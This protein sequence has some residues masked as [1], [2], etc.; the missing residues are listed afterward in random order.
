MILVA[1]GITA[2][3]RSSGPVV[4]SVDAAKPPNIVRSE[5]RPDQSKVA[6]GNSAAGTAEADR[7]RVEMDD[8]RAKLL[9]AEQ[10]AVGLKT[11]LAQRNGEIAQLRSN[12][13]DSEQQL[14]A[15]QSSISILSSRNEDLVAS[16]VAERAHQSELTAQV[17][18]ERS[19]SEQDRQLTT[20]AREVRELMG[21]RRLYMIDVYD[22]NDPVHANR[23]FGRVFYTEG[24]SLIFYAFDL[25]KVKSSKRVTFAAWGEH[26]KDVAS[27]K[28]L[29][30]FDLDDAAQKRWVM[31]VDDPDKLKSIDA[32]FVTVE[33]KPGVGRPSGQKLLYAYLGGSPNHP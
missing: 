24:K 15:A 6:A 4:L 27:I 9:S 23:S 5:A 14:R 25:D 26:G 33:S 32:I 21:A 31:R 8:L 30:V 29:G 13:A 1:V 22:G 20:V 18:Q 12:Y 3:P 16:L 7:Q 2:V 19:R 17:Q 28:P 10:D 11:Q